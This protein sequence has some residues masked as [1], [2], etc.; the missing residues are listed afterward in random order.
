MEGEGGVLW[1]AGMEGM[2][3]VRGTTD[4]YKGCVPGAER[5][6]ESGMTR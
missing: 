6:G 1:V 4:R 2:F 5:G 3:Q